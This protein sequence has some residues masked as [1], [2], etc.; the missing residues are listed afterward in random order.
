MTFIL[1]V[2]LYLASLRM[3]YT[4]TGGGGGVG[5]WLDK[6]ILKLISAPVWALA[7]A[8]LGKMKVKG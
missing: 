5:G 2:L 1:E 4:F 8:E 3:N 7:G 6:P